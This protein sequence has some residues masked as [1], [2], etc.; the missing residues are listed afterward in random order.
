MFEHNRPGDL[1]QVNIRIFSVS[2]N[3]VKSIDHTINSKGNR[4]FEIQWDGTDHFGQK[5]GRGVYIYQIN[6]KDNN[7]NK[8]KARQKLVLL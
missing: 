6:I 4:S 1:L 8:Q 2:G 7:G 5:V 3:L